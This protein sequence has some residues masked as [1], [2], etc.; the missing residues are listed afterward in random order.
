MA[1]RPVGAP[2]LTDFDFYF[3]ATSIPSP[4]E[5]EVLLRTIYLSLDPYMRGRMS[6]A[7][8]YADPVAINEVMVGGAVCRVE[9]SNNSNFSVV[10]W[11]VLCIPL[12]G[13]I[14]QYNATELPSG[15]DR[16]LY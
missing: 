10:E 14:S 2:T 5:E 3:A 1:S 9:Q 16:Y 15:P 4:K 7:K 13:L 8:S 12:C 6:D 11:V